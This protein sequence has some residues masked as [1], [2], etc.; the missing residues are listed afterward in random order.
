VVAPTRELAIQTHDT[1]KVISAA[2]G[3]ESVCVFGGVSKNDQIRLL[4]S[5]NVRFLVGTPGRLL[6][7][8]QDGACDL[9]KISY[10]VLDEADRMLDKGFENDIRTIIGLTPADGRQT[11]MC[12][13]LSCIPGVG[14]LTRYQSVQ[15][16]P[17][18]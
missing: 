12:T 8:A 2:F 7:L 5:P 15:P 16:G 14:W 11:V 17:H 9:S 18:Q 10:L 4:Q 1:L 3:V 13:F 6:D